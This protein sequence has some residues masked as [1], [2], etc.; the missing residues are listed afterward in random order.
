MH[1]LCSVITMTI[2]T[3]CIC[4]QPYLTTLNPPP[5]AISLR[6]VQIKALLDYIVHTFM[7]Y[8]IYLLS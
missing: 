3:N 2:Y 7:D 6:I 8:T 5:L 4:C 1:G